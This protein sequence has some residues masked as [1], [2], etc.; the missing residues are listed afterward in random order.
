[1][2]SGRGVGH[3]VGK[4]WD[5]GGQGVGQRG[6][7]VHLPDGHAGP[8][9]ALSTQIYEANQRQ[10]DELWDMGWDKG[11]RRWDSGLTGQSPR[12]CPT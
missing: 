8:A 9:A 1:M 10:C 6:T 7:R 11:G 4:G 12:P 5:R 2:S 3:G